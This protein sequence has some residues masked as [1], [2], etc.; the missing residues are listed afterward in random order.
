MLHPP[1][2]ECESI[3]R[4]GRQFAA[5]QHNAFAAADGSEAVIL[6]NATEKRQ[7][8]TLTWHGKPLSL[9]LEPEEVRLLNGAK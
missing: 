7:H 4:D 3:E 6:A 8:A 9:D 2:L 5:V 1:R